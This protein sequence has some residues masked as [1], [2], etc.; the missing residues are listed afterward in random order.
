ML[1]L[2]CFSVKFPYGRLA[3]PIQISPQKT[4]A[5][6]CIYKVRIHKAQYQFCESILE[7]KLALN[8]KKFSVCKYSVNNSRN[9]H[10]RRAHDLKIEKHLTYFQVHD[11]LDMLCTTTSVSHR[12]KV[13][14]LSSI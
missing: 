4:N 3:T 12:N 7:F 8:D 2:K 10:D 9:M 13:R 11:V 6:L 14:K 5:Q 1:K